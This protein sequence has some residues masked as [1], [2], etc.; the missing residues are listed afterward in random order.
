M[1]I[2]NKVMLKYAALVSNYQRFSRDATAK[3]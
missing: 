2:D 1:S 3:G